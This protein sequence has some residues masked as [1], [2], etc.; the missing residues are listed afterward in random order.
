MGI[1]QIQFI[2]LKN[3]RWEKKIEEI[4]FYFEERYIVH[5]SGNKSPIQ[6]RND[7]EQI[8]WKLLKM[9]YNQQ[10]FL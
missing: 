5:I 8:I 10:S 9:L 7:F 6:S 4:L 3:S 2:P 1:S